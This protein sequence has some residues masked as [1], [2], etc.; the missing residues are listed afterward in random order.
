MRIRPTVIRFLLLL[1]SVGHL[2]AAEEISEKSALPLALRE[3]NP[4]WI[5][6]GVYRHFSAQGAWPNESAIVAREA[7]P[8]HSPSKGTPPDVLRSWV[9]ANT[10]LGA[11]PSALPAASRQQAEPHIFRS[12]TNPHIMLATFQEG[13]RSDGGAASCGYAFSQDGG[14][15]W[16]RALIPNLTQVNGG[17]Y[18]R[19]TDPVAAIDL[20]GRMYLNTLNARTSDFGLADITISRTED[21][22]ETW[23]DPQVVFAAPNTQVFPDKNWMTVND[24]A[25]SLTQG[26]LAV[27]FTTFTS[28]A[29]GA[30]RGNNLRCSTSD[31]QGRTWSVPS[32]ITPTGSSNQGTQPL[33]L[34]DGS[35][36]VSYIRFLS[37]TS[38]Q[39]ESKTSSDGGATWPTNGVIIGEV[40]FPWDDP[41]TRDGSFLIS[42]AIARQTGSLFVTWTFS[43]ANTARIAVTRSDDGGAT[44]SAFRIPNEFAVGRSA[45]N[46]TVSSSADGQ[47][48][49]VTWM[50]TRNAPPE[51]SHVDMYAS[52]S[53]DGGATWSADFRIS[54][55]TTDVRLSQL[56]GRGYMLGDYY[57]LAAAPTPND[58]TVAVWVDTRSGEADPIATRFSP[59]PTESYDNWAVAHLSARA[60]VDGLAEA[61]PDGDAYPNLFEYNYGLDP[62][63]AD[64][65]SALELRHDSGNSFIVKDPAFGERSDAGTATWQQSADGENWSRASISS[66]TQASGTT[67]LDLPDAAAQAVYLR[68]IRDR[69]GQRVFSSDYTLAGGQSLLTNLSTRGL[70]GD[71]LEKMVPAFVTAGEGA[72]VLLRAVGPTL[73]DFGVSAPMVDPS[74]AVTPAP[75][76]GSGRNDNWQ[77]A[78]GATAS[79]F[80]TFGAFALPD[81]SAD[82]AL[83]ATLGSGP[84]TAAITSTEVG[85][86][87]VLTELYLDAESSDARLTNLSTRAPVGTGDGVLIGGFVITGESPRRCLIRAAGESLADFGITSPLIDP[88]LQIFPSGST[89]AIAYND[90]WKTGPSSTNIA[91]EG[92]RVGAFYFRDNSRDAALIVT[93]DPGAYT[94]VVSGVDETTG[95]SLVEIYLLE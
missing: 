60:A 95:I 1:I 77:D 84:S 5:S 65:G 68:A 44:W 3:V 89:Q 67:Q 6:S 87:V 54:D 88:R 79:N 72:T 90:D 58:P 4:A 40:P 37:Q 16:D 14:Y 50:D 27:T 85:N 57:G 34:P 29:T 92:G 76:T 73:T 49:T 91:N 78:N 83:L 12:F 48:V 8:T 69:N 35:L 20:E 39:V 51:G 59:I 41:D 7:L 21:Q 43:S 18:F 45:F 56:T 38:F 10:I 81:G 94:A 63:A 11:D 47:T 52:T 23:S 25:S 71:G 33:F 32:F 13:R 26:R 22:G 31:D 2:P 55:R 9:A 75:T 30:A 15:T 46:P 28:T 70:S 61:N 19:A 82:A 74:L 66:S 36:F 93:L 53:T 80:T 86:R 17:A 62:L 42:A 64:S 24:M